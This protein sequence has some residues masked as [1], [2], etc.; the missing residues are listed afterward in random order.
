MAVIRVEKNGNYTTMCN[1]HLRDGN[2]SLKAKGLLSL[3]LSLPDSWDYSVAGLVKITRE[4]KTVILST[5]KELKEAG[6]IVV[7]KFFPNETDS[8]RYEYEYTVYEVPPS[9]TSD[10][11]Q[12]P[13]NKVLETSTLKQEPCNKHLETRSLNNSFNQSSIVSTA[14]KELK[15]SKEKGI[16]GVLEEYAMSDELKNVIREFATMRKQSRKPIVS[17]HALRLLIK[18]LKELASDEPTQIAI[19]N[20][21]VMNS[22]LSFYPLKEEARYGKTGVKLADTTDHELDE[23]F[24]LGSSW[25]E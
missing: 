23:V 20:Q 21:S 1:V 8:G 19:V 11:K 22:W 5:L 24:S 16:D 18:K 12:A 3:M 25:G 17:D 2:L 13:C 7:K 15:A 6:Y 4:G 9:K 14:I 10:Q